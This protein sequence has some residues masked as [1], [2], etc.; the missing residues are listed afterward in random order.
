MKNT[1]MLKSRYEFKKILYKGKYFSS[2]NIVVYIVSNNLDNKNQLGICVSKKNGGSVQRNKLKRWVRE[3]YKQL[4]PFTKKKYD[5]IV[6]YKKTANI[7]NLSFKIVKEELIKCFK[8][9]SIC[10][11]EEII[12]EKDA[13]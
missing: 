1:T 13:Y 4:E 7:Q 2:N 3:I 5:I 11:C 9:L 10:D 8:K 12:D 6:L